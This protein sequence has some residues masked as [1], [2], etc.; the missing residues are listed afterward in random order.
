MVVLTPQNDPVGHVDRFAGVS[1]TDPAGHADGAVE[2]DGHQ[3][4]GAQ[5]VWRWC[6]SG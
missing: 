1:H 6:I 5:G 2:L 4:P 3:S